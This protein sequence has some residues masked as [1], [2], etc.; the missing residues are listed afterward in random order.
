MVFPYFSAF[1]I[2]YTGINYIFLA[3]YKYLKLSN[4]SFLSQI[5]TGSNSYKKQ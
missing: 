2:I 1:Y 5:K 4:I 3:N